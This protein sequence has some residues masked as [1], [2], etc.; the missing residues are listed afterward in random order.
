MARHRGVRNRQFSYDEEEGDFYDE[1]EEAR[2]C[3]EHRQQMLEARGE[4][5]TSA[6]AN[7]AESRRSSGGGISL[8]SYFDVPGTTS[9]QQQQ[10]QSRQQTHR[11]GR[12]PEG[13]ADRHPPDRP[14]TGSHSAG[15]AAA[16]ADLVAAVAAE[17][18]SRVGKGRFSPDQLRRAIITSGYEVDTAQA[19]LLTSSDGE[20]QFQSTG[21]DDSASAGLPPPP[22][23]GTNN[24][25]SSLAFGLCVDGREEWKRKSV[26]S[27]SG[28]TIPDTSKPASN[29]VSATAPSVKPFGFDTPSPDDINM[30][31]QAGARGGGI[32]GG[33]GTSPKAKVL[34]IS[35]STP[36]V[37][38]RKSVPAITTPSSGRGPS[39]GKSPTAIAAS[40]ISP[41]SG[42]QSPTKVGSTAALRSGAARLES[43]SDEEEGGGKERLA[44]VVIGHVDAGKSTLMGQV[45]LR[46]SFCVTHGC[47]SRRGVDVT[48]PC[49]YKIARKIQ[50]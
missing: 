14:D 44:M 1:D 50:L 11:A 41:R 19:I 49:W 5:D 18:E 42:G 32:S 26:V 27:I 20:I 30:S 34:H 16:D 39:S 2:A 28:T 15:G 3:E 17:L 36:T 21:A 4:G 45:R 13:S 24:S 47:R 25:P 8:S 29:T 9:R 48:P 46:T 40:K 12:D 7:N 23:L 38:T 31:R 6:A 33:G 43:A 35:G 10:Q 22:G 37:A